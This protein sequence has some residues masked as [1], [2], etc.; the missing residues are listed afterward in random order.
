MTQPSEQPATDR[1]ATDGSGPTEPAERRQLTSAKEMRAL[2][3]PLRV[4]A[5]ELLAREGPMTATQ[6]GEIL[7]ESPAN[8]SF[9]LRTL[10]KYGFIEETPGGTGRERL[11]S[12]VGRGT[13]WEM[14]SEDAATASAALGLS[15]HLAQRAYERRQEWDLTRSTYPREWRQASFVYD[16]TTYLTADELDALGE[17]IS[18][19]LE[20]YAE[21]TSD[22]TLRPEGAEPVSIV[23]SGHPLPP[24]PSGN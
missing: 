8:M 16:I 15:R 20:R 2:A 22:R 23:V 19:L 7:G 18:A 11:W 1:D 10:A 13:A 4:A 9:H 3:H 5:T 21:R 12:R 17:Q 6:L 14:D 24:T